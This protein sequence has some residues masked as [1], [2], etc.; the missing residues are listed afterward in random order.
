MI[1]TSI[2][3]GRSLT[4]DRQH[5]QIESLVQALDSRFASR[6]RANRSLVSLLNSLTAH[7]QMHFELEEDECYFA[8]VVKKAPS[9]GPEVERLVHEHALLLAEASRLVELSKEAFSK[10]ADTAELANRFESFRE[11]LRKHE[12]AEC[13]LVEVALRE[14]TVE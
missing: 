5:A 11:R 7:L 13:E 9:L 6:Q 12:L 8:E 10:C 2:P 14:K 4:I 1:T 3:A